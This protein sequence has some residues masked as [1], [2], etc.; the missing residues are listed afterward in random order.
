LPLP[1]DID[2]TVFYSGFFT[3]LRVLPKYLKV[4]F[5]LEECQ[6]MKEEEC[7]WRKA[8]IA[9]MIYSL[10]MTI[11][12]VIMGVI[13]KKKTKKTKKTKKSKKRIEEVEGGIELVEL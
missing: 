12:N 10:L 13:L 5:V 6:P 1:I 11:I 7:Q 3:R 4:Y 8:E 2:A 9:N